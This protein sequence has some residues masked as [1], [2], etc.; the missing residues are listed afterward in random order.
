MTQSIWTTQSIQ[1]KKL[2]RWSCRSA[3]PILE[4]ETAQRWPIRDCPREAHPQSEPAGRRRRT[5]A[6]ISRRRRDR[7]P[8]PSGRAGLCPSRAIGSTPRQV[9]SLRSKRRRPWITANAPGWSVSSCWAVRVAPARAATK[10]TSQ[11]RLNNRG[12]SPAA[13]SNATP[14]PRSRHEIVPH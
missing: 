3:S 4:A 14:V 5:V 1:S 10:P 8:R 11:R 6:N 9:I 12:R 7:P 13:A 2:W